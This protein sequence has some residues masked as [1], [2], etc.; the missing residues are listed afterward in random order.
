MRNRTQ[1]KILSGLNTLIDLIDKEQNLSPIYEE[2]NK[3]IFKLASEEETREVNKKIKFCSDKISKLFDQWKV[4]V[5]FNDK[6]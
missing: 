4:E 2:N 5:I 1:N 6:N 3:I